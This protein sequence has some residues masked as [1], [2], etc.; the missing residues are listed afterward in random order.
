M[1]VQQIQCALSHTQTAV[2]D[3]HG[4][5]TELQDSQAA[6]AKFAVA[7]VE[8]LQTS[9]GAVDTNISEVG[10]IADSL[11]AQSADHHQAEC[12]KVGATPVDVL[13]QCAAVHGHTRMPIRVHRRA[14]SLPVHAV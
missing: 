5:S 14:G 8:T 9:S 3:M 12:G 13:R 6:A 2:A 4:A 11:V 1:V 10:N 7:V